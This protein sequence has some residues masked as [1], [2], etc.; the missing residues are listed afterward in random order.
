M[1]Q[2]NM[3]TQELQN[4]VDRLRST[5]SWLNKQPGKIM[6]NVNGMITTL[7]REQRLP[8]EFL[9]K[10]GFGEKENRDVALIIRQHA[11]IGLSDR[12]VS[13]IKRQREAGG[14]DYL[15]LPE[16]L[17]EY[18]LSPDECG[19]LL[20]AA[21][22]IGKRIEEGKLPGS[23]WLISYTVMMVANSIEKTFISPEKSV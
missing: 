8:K 7:V 1:V 18:L 13:L 2:I 10:N 20:G 5:P 14:P 17:S 4:M 19:K 22:E 23:Q 12:D 11:A 16:G 15:F 21:Q 6:E 3:K 9:P